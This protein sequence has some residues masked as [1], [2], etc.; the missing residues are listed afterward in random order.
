MLANPDPGPLRRRVLAIAAFVTALA[1]LAPPP[2]GWLPPAGEAGGVLGSLLTAQAAVVAL[3]LAISL[4]LLQ[5]ARQDAGERMYREYVRA[6]GTRP[7]FQASLAMLALT[8]AAALAEGAIA[9]RPDAGLFRAVPGLSDPVRVAALAFAAN[10]LLAL[11]QFEQA[12]RLAD[13]AWRRRVEREK[14]ERDVRNAVQAFLDRRQRMLAKPDRD[15]AAAIA[16]LRPDP[17]EGLA[18]TAVRAQLDDARRAMDE[19][20]ADDFERALESIVHLTGYAMDEIERPGI[21]WQPPGHGPEW[22]P[23]RELL[24]HLYPFREDVIGRGGREH[25]F[26][27]LKLDHWLLST[28]AKRR[29]GELF[30]AGLDAYRHNYEIASRIGNGDLRDLFR[31]RAWL[32]VPFLFHDM[33]PEEC[34][35]Y[36]KYAIRH[37]ERLLSRA[38]HD[39]NPGD[40]AYIQAGFAR[41]L[42]TL[43]WRWDAD[44]WPRPG[45]DVHRRLLDA[46]RSGALPYSPGLYAAE[47]HGEMEQLHGIALMGLA[48]RA[49]RLAAA[50]RLADPE[51]YLDAAR[52][53]YV[54]AG[55]L[56][57]D[58]AH[59]LAHDMRGTFSWREWEMEGAGNER[60]MRPVHPQRY[61]L[62]FFSLRLSELAGEPLPEIDLHGEAQ[63]VL[64]WFTKNA[65]SLERHVRAGPDASMEWRR[66]RAIAALQAAVRRDEAARDEDVI[67]RPLS[68]DAITAFTA[69]V[70]A[71][72]YTA[73][74]VDRIFASA[75]AARC[76]PADADGAPE[77]RGFFR[78]L[79]HKGPFTDDPA[80]GQ[81]ARIARNY[82]ARL[83]ADVLRQLCEAL[84]SAQEI[85]MPLHGAEDFTRA[86]DA[87][88]A[89]LA[90]SSEALVVLAG[91][92]IG[93]LVDLD[94]E[95]PDGYEHRWE[96]PD[97]G[98]GERARYR[99]RPVI[100]G[101][102]D[103]GRRLYVV[104]PGA[105]G[106]LVRAPAGDGQELRVE[107]RDISPER[108][109][110]HLAKNP[111]LEPDEPDEAVKLRKLQTCCE[112][113]IV[114]RVGFRVRDPARA[115]CVRAP[116]T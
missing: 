3:M 6:L 95:P 34:A 63:R 53:E 52:S 21:G 46:V 18:D 28:G 22:P 25:A 58:A 38:L 66:E 7:V 84:D 93:V 74:A 87:A 77:E 49:V 20:R 15:L 14:N 101:V 55:R 116:A 59:A 16:A 50:G 12:H 40:Y 109:K 110:W 113:L 108:A 78:Q 57:D 62:T 81:A 75:G 73:D 79:V 88:F 44:R 51:P 32:D 48:G 33:G 106:C 94:L 39:G 100:M 54:E 30:A 105:W 71:A 115:R 98:E 60:M 80:S 92:W 47:L 37:Q 67:R 23:L 42:D 27:L 2:F 85:A 91:D 86:A 31:D 70:Y 36:L 1:V 8:G 82:G 102:H 107:V 72:A 68:E 111:D 13:P 114:H 89:S 4:F 97:H 26:G 64:D 43:G 17:G 65:E 29:C 90:A 41:V 11:V 56:A 24:R 69:N 112:I 83:A 99:G 10:V 5:G 9:M 96:L 19:H 61:P 35:P 104:E 76:V 45:T 103:G